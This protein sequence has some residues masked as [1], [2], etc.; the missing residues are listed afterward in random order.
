MA[1]ALELS[2]T[3]FRKI[4]PSED[5]VLASSLIV[6]MNAH[7]CDAVFIMDCYIQARHEDVWRRAGG[8]T[9]T[10]ALQTVPR[11]EDG[12]VSEESLTYKFM[13]NLLPILEGKR[14]HSMKYPF[15]IR[16]LLAQDRTLQSNF[17][18]QPFLRRNGRRICIDPDRLSGR[19][20]LVFKSYPRRPRVMTSA[21]N[22]VNV[23]YVFSVCFQLPIVVSANNYDRHD[24]PAT[25]EGISMGPDGDDE[26]DD[27]DVI[28][29]DHLRA[30]I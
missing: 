20:E 4:G 9:E 29:E 30:A 21:L 2:L 1:D 27:D 16:E 11:N 28:M 14:T 22:S 18:P 24:K 23:M 25:D 13:E 10:Y 15:S 19:G 12:P 8:D 6:G 17:L 7:N 26:E 3:D 5:R